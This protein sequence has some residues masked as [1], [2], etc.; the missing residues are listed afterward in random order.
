MEEKRAVGGYSTIFQ[1]SPLFP[2]F[3]PLPFVLIFIQPSLSIKTQQARKPFQKSPSQQM[4][5]VFE[6]PFTKSLSLPIPQTIQTTHQPSLSPSRL[7]P[8]VHPAL[9]SSPLI[10]IPKFLF[11]GRY[12]STVAIP[13]SIPSRAYLVNRLSLHFPSLSKGARK[14]QLTSPQINFSRY[15]S[16]CMEI[17][18]L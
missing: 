5:P 3:S 6:L 1:T 16:R 18:F 13:F 7:E 12:I 10:Q 2:F 15:P 11:K 14:E 9:S 17:G 8:P 4:N